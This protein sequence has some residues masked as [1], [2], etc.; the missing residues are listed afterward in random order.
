MACIRVKCV[1]AKVIHLRVS[2][3]LMRVQNDFVTD[4]MKR[5]HTSPDYG[6]SRIQLKKF[7]LFS[8]GHN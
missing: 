2:L 3:L 5:H 1:Y 6:M 7:N 8:H 4:G